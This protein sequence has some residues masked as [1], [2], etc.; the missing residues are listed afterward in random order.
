[1]PFTFNGFGTRHYGEADHYPNGSFITTQWLTALYL[2]LIP[3]R[4]YRLAPLDKKAET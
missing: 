1:M 4:S 2:P 3:L